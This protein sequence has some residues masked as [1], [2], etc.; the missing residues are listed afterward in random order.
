[1]K[2]PESFEPDLAA[3]LRGCGEAAVHKTRDSGCGGF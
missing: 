1:M 3:K 2:N